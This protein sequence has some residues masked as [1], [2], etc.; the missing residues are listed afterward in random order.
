MHLWHSNEVDRAFLCRLMVKARSV[1]PQQRRLPVIDRPERSALRVV[2]AA[3]SVGGRPAGHPG[4]KWAVRSS[5]GGP[6][7]RRY[8]VRLNDRPHAH[9][10]DARHVP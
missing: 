2:A 8:T 3:H 6:V 4:D 9:K 10:G 7:S 1:Q 5:S